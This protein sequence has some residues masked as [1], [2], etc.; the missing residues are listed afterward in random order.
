[1]TKSTIWIRHRSRPQQHDAAPAE[2][3][4][5]VALGLRHVAV[6]AERVVKA[7]GDEQPLARIRPGADRCPEQSERLDQRGAERRPTGAER[8][9]TAGAASA[10][11]GLLDEAPGLFDPGGVGHGAGCE[12]QEPR[13]ARGCRGGLE[14]A[15]RVCAEVSRRQPAPSAIAAVASREPASATITSRTTP[16]AAPA[17][18]AANVGSSARSLSCVAITTL[19]MSP[20]PQGTPGE[21]QL[22]GGAGSSVST[23]LRAAS[24][25]SDGYQSLRDS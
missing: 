11:F 5:K 13:R 18:S 4:A 22:S 15:P 12:K 10:Q 17:T 1:M 9:G 19:S 8:G 6:P 16:A 2:A 14:A 21:D 25:R 23:G 7:P 24:C 20:C 3:A